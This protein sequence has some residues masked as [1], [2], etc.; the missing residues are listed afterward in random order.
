MK[1]IGFN[2]PLPE[3]TVHVGEAM[4]YRNIYVQGLHH[5][6]KTAWGEVIFSGELYH[7]E[8]TD[9]NNPAAFVAAH[10]QQHDIASVGQISGKFLC[11]LLHQESTYIIRD[12]SG[13]ENP[14]YY[15]D[16]IFSNSIDLILQ[17][18]LF[19]AKAD[20]ASVALFLK[21]G[22]IPAPDTP[23]ENLK[24]LAPFQYIEAG[25]TGIRLHETFSFEKFLEKAETN[26]LTWEETVDAYEKM[27]KQAIQS[28]IRG[29]Q[30]VGLLLSG[31]YD[32]GGNL[33]VL[34]DFYDGDITAYSVGFE[35]NT[36]SELPLATLMAEKFNA[37]ITPFILDGSEMEALPK[38]LAAFE[39]PFFEN[40]LFINHKVASSINPAETDVLLGGD[41]ND[42]FFGTSSRELALNIL[43][44]KTGFIM[45]Q[46]L[47]EL[48]APSLP[49]MARLKFHNDF[50]LNAAELQHFGY[51]AAEIRKLL[52]GVRMDQNSASGKRKSLQ[53][54]KLYLWRNYNT[55]IVKSAL[56]VINH[57]ASRLAGQAG[58]NIAFPYADNQVLSLLNTLKVEQKVKG[59]FKEIVRGKGKS[60]FLLK[61][62]LKN[63]LPREI[64]HRKKQGGFAP[65]SIYLDSAEMRKNI[66]SFV[67]STSLTSD[68]FE[69]RTLDRILK[70]I[71][72]TL[73]N[74]KEWFWQ[75][76]KQQSRLMYLLVIS[77]WWRVYVMQDNRP[78]MSD[79]FK[80]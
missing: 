9:E 25:A 37:K 43:S 2:N 5:Y 23:F 15:N 42:Q 55:D 51:S 24:K 62:C 60:K 52:P 54:N 1:F 72:K 27:H 79:Y 17:S 35:N 71:E 49:G 14:V 73:L 77:L 56:Q 31:G 57:K 39:E 61:D 22:F 29:K 58:L 67:W 68:L 21:Q 78:R 12:Q 66:Y 59:S 7:E 36:L 48:V 30:K 4:Q 6:V 74:T 53:F 50:I 11:I 18:G 75:R 10:V 64:T 26:P 20:K 63:K 13:T 46:R 47:F 34:R 32:S 8:E 28:R 33:S 16:R 69:K 19:K 65:L 44:R 80:N 45:A 40:G 38:I 3:S 41:G 70:D 76:Q